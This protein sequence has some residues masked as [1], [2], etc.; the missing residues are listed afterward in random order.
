M[1]RVLSSDVASHIGSSSP[2][3]RKKAALALNRILKRV[4]E[5]SAHYVDNVIALLRDRS[6]GVL[7]TAIQ[8]LANVIIPSLRC[9]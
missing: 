7:V 8:L 9:S 4:P 2:Y 3:I 1:G 6:H 5:L